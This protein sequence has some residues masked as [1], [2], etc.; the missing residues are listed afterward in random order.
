MKIKLVVHLIWKVF[1]TNYYPDFFFFYIKIPLKDLGMSL[2]MRPLPKWNMIL[3]TKIDLVE[4]DLSGVYN[5]PFIKE[6]A[7][8][9]YY[10]VMT[11]TS[12]LPPKKTNKHY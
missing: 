8:R 6:G 5:I 9:N 11:A 4:A 7:I 3:S 1:V 10:V 12:P 2:N